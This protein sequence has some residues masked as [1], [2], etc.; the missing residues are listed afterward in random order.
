MSNLPTANNVSTILR[1][2]LGRPV[3]VKDDRVRLQGDV[4]WARY[5]NES[6]DDEAIWSWDIT[7]GVCVGAALTMVPADQAQ[8]DI[9]KGQVDAMAIEN[10]QEVANVLGSL[11]NGDGKSRMVLREVGF[12]DVKKGK[13]AEK[14]KA[15]KNKAHYIVNIDG[16]GSGPSELR[17]SA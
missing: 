11:L 2:L 16:Y 1:D 4:L 7:P 17:R 8:Q 15:M 5:S 13:V 10:F 6:G 3:S 14:A 9:K 12:D